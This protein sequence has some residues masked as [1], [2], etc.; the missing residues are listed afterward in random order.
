MRLVRLP[1]RAAFGVAST[2]LVTVMMTAG[3]PGPL[4][5]TY[6]S[7]TPV[8]T[9]GITAAYAAYLLAA[10]FAMLVLGRRPTALLALATGMAGCIAMLDVQ[11]TAPLVIGRALQGI[12]TGLAMSGI[13]AMVVDLRTPER[14]LLASLVVS[15]SPTVGVALGAIASGVALEMHPGRTDTAYLVLLVLMTVLAVGVLCSAET[16]TPPP[17]GRVVAVARAVRPRVA[18]PEAARPLFLA[19]VASYFAAWVLG[20]F[21]QSLGPSLAELA[22]PSTGPIFAGFTVAAMLGLTVAGGPLTSRLAPETGTLVGLGVL[23]ASVVAVL[24]AVELRLA[25]LFIVA[26]MTAGIGFGACTAGSMRSLLAR[27]G[28]TSPAGLLAATY[29]TTYVLATVPAFGGGLLVA[30]HGLATM[31]WW[32]GGLVIALAAI[33]AAL[34]RRGARRSAREGHADLADPGVAR[35][36]HARFGRRRVEE[37]P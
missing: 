29:L 23:A 18:V 33:G 2:T 36:V 13:G 28:S 35:G 5:P 8:T 32:Y 22:F 9:V 19:A 30:R 20:G 34:T 26:S 37:R 6:V 1:R 25:P 21:Y 24:L 27:I 31:V 11:S 17:E 12:S 14:H 15:A 10:T 16:S 7:T 3:I 4:Q